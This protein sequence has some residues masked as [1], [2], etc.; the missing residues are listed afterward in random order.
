VNPEMALAPSRRRRRP[1]EGEGSRRAGGE[2]EEEGEDWSL[3]EGGRR[4]L[5]LELSPFWLS[6]G[7]FSQNARSCVHRLGYSPT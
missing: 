6:D 2:K 1:L 7:L 5:G 3:G 4:E